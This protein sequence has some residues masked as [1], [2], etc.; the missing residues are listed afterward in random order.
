MTRTFI[1]THE[2]TKQWETMSLNDDDH[3]RLENMILEDPKAGRVI[4]GTGR[5]RKVRFSFEG[6]GKSGSVRVC[7]VDFEDYETIYLITAYSKSQKDNLTK[8]ERNNVKKMID[9]LESTL[10]GNV[11]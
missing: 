9:I 4:R 11:L 2:F 5:L 8:A 6:K 7:Y 1:Q 10:G 3:R